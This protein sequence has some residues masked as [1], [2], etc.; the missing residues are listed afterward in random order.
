MATN[1]GNIIFAISADL[2]QIQG[3]LR[4][5]EGNFQSSFS[6]IESLG[7]NVLGTLG[8][9]LSGAAIVAFGKQVLDLAGHLD[10]LSKQTGISVQTLSGIKSTLEENGTTVDAFSKA[11]FNLQKNL[12]NVDSATD[13]AAKAIKAFG[14]NLDELRNLNTDEFVTKVVNA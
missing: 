2:K 10:D 6:K 11:V 5:L 8:I 12:G 14:L 4:T 7:K 1:V 9:G 3:Q 13:P